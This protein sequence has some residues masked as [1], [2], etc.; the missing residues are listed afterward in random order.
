MDK[1][2]LSKW[3][4]LKSIKYLMFGVPAL[5]GIIDGR[6]E[7]MNILGIDFMSFTAGDFE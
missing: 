5:N 6:I 4:L 1:D 7:R 3:N 2:C